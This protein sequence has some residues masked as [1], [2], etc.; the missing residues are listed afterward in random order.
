[1]DGLAR[2]EKL[3]RK[4][5][6]ITKIRE[7]ERERVGEGGETDRHAIAWKKTSTISCG[8]V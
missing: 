6:D 5:A 2:R 8:V 1:M 3:E 4:E 7:R